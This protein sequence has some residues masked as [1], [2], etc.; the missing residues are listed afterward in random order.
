METYQEIEEAYALRLGPII[1]YGFEVQVMPDVRAEITRPTRS[2]RLTVTYIKSRFGDE[3]KPGRPEIRS[4]GT[5]HQEEH[6]EL[7]IVVETDRRRGA[8]GAYYAMEYIR[9]LL[10]GYEPLPGFG[11]TAFMRVE[12]MEYENSFY[13][14]EIVISTSRHVVPAIT[15][16]SEMGS[17]LVEDAP[18]PEYTFLEGRVVANVSE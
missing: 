9:R 14:Y 10:L 2:S 4:A 12:F 11:R 18:T 6:I 16:E 17:I 3:T 5:P 7:S 15:P 13:K 1:D 8:T